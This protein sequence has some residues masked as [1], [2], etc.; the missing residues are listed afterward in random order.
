[1][2]KITLIGANLAN[3]YYEQIIFLLQAS[4]NKN[5]CHDIAEI[6]LNVVLNSIILT[7]NSNFDLTRKRH[8]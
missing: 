4:T 3:T 7:Q 5:D 8:V 1:M 6:L 2:S